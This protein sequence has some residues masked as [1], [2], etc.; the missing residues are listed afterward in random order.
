MTLSD[1]AISFAILCIVITVAVAILGTSLD[2]WM[3]IEER[4]E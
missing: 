1:L 3:D 2:W 4:C